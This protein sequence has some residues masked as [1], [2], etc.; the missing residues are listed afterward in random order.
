LVEKALQSERSRSY[1]ALH[2]LIEIRLDLDQ[3]AFE[4][5]TTITGAPFLKEAATVPSYRDMVRRA[6]E[7]ALKLVEKK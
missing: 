7:T 2:Y 3:K 6:A 4:G 5:A 1:D